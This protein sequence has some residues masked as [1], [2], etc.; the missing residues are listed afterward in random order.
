MATAT[1]QLKWCTVRFANESLWWVQSVN[2]GIHWDFD[3]LAIIDPRQ[4]QHLL[5]ILSSMREYG[6]QHDIVEN[7]FF[8]F[9]LQ[10]EMT[11]KRFRLE[12]T[13]DS[14]HDPDHALFALP[15][16]IDEE[17]GPFED[18]MSHIL[19]VRV[20]MLNDL[21][22][23]DQPLTPEDV[24]AEIREAQ[25]TDL[26][27]EQTSHCFAEITAVLE[28][29]P[30][31]VDAYDIKETA[32]SEKAASIET[33]GDK[34]LADGYD[35]LNEDDEAFKQDK[36]ALTWDQEEEEQQRKRDNPELDDIMDE[37]MDVEEKPKPRR[38]RPRKNP[39]D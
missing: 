22:D 30:E 13:R 25:N 36:E 12:R 7:A 38:G 19:R 24:D 3:K 21:I 31:G 14:I 9:K 8:K 34:E 39:I 27:E 6:L 16:D 33:P 35:V 17:Q 29:T 20:R 5:E 32:E 15:N 11:N 4:L 2:P 10:K 1:T 23:S 37:R 18:F 26:L 28:Y